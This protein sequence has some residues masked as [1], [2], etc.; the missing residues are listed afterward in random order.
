MTEAA[1]AR[2]E[3]TPF[4]LDGAPLSSQQDLSQSPTP[5]SAQVPTAESASSSTQDPERSEA[6]PSMTAGDQERTLRNWG[7]LAAIVL[8]V[9]IF[10][11]NS[12]R[13]FTAEDDAGSST[14]PIA[15]PTPSNISATD[16]TAI[17]AAPSSDTGVASEESGPFTSM[18]P[19]PE[20]LIGA[21][22]PTGSAQGAAAT[23]MNA[24]ETESAHLFPDSVA[25]V[26]ATNSRSAMEMAAQAIAEQRYPDALNF[27][28]ETPIGKQTEDYAALLAQ[29]K[30]GIARLEA[31]NRA[32]LNDARDPIH[33]IQ[34]SQFN[35]AI[36]QARRIRPGEPLYEQAQRDIDR[37]SRVILDLAEGRATD[38]NFVAA[39]AAAELVPPDRPDVYQLAQVYIGRWRRQQE[40]RQVL[41]QARNSLQ[42]GQASSFHDAIILVGKIT[43]DQPEY[44][45]ARQLANQWSQDI[46]N[47]ARARAAQGRFPDAILAASLVPQDTSAY[48]Q[49]QVE[50]QRWSE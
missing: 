21:S 10:Y 32:L 19:N 35:D 36:T 34:A 1:A 39:L 38:G 23:D 46:L 31:S 11:G 18:R 8:V 48:N 14:S 37:W 33:S 24:L 6:Q 12:P 17:D 47:I 29:A 2:I 3:E 26:D 49:A 5:H 28:E 4:T 13:L 40:N 44:P 45:I 22:S 30:A 50:I 27:L 15:S 42:A 20:N 16:K 9:A 41:Q 7:I 43:D 25:P